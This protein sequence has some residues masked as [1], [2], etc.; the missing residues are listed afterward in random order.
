MTTPRN[1]HLLL[2]YIFLACLILLLLNDHLFKTAYSNWLTGKLSD[3]AGIILLPLLLAYLLPVIRYHAIWVSAVL[4]I[5]WKL[6]LSSGLI[7][8]YNRVAPVQITRVV[9]YSDLLVLL[10]LPVP[11]YIMRNI[12][13]LSVIAIKRVHPVFVLIPVMAS[14]MATSPP[15][16]YRYVRT[17]GNLRCYGCTITLRYNQDEI[18]QKLQEDHIVFDSIKPFTSIS[19][20]GDTVNQTDLKL[21]KINQL[22]IDGDTLRDLDFTMRTIKEGK[23]RVY[24]TGMNVDA[25]MDDLKLINR[26]RKLY[27]KKVFSELRKAAE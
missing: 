22:V 9:D 10:L 12:G 18:V 23:T 26:L 17:E 6:P 27:K 24:F 20:N 21:Y 14:F 1:R 19:Y 15:R 4:F 16:Y 7:D 11:F 13:H 2:N 8:V 5:F 3:A 25:N